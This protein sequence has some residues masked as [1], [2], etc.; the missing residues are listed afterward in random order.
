L[1]TLA[2]FHTREL[3]QSGPELVRALDAIVRVARQAAGHAN[4]PAT[5]N[6]NRRSATTINQMGSR[7]KAAAR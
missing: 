6:A 7:R 2:E 3:E 1:A 5:K 4:G